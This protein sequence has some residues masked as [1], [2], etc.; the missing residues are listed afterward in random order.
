LPKARRSL[1]PICP[2]C[3]K[4]PAAIPLREA[5]LHRARQRRQQRIRSNQ[6]A[7]LRN[8]CRRVI[9]IVRMGRAI[10]AESDRNRKTR[11]AFA[12]EQNSGRLGLPHKQIIGPFDI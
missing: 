2:D 11:L 1:D 10:D 8:V 9:G 6:R 3:S 5:P 12:L 7:R 4:C